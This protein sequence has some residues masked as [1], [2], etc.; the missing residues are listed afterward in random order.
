VVLG[1]VDPMATT[2]PAHSCPQ[3]KGAY[4]WPWRYAAT[5][6][7]QIPHRSTGKTAEPGMGSGSGN[8]QNSMELWP[9]I[10]AARMR[11]IRFPSAGLGVSS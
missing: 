7:P 9:V 11:G 3:R 10:R 2:V 4:G 6:V 8:S 1:E 5:S